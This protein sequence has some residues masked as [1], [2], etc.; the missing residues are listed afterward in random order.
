MEYISILL[1]LLISAITLEYKYKVHLYHSRKE[2]FLIVGLFFIIGVAWDH[3]AVYRSHWNF[4]GN[5]LSGMKIG[6]I[7]LEEYLF[8]LILPYW[9]LTVYKILDKKLK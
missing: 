1:L 9:I 7:P 2:R 8:I 3:L 5:G 4:P 6:L